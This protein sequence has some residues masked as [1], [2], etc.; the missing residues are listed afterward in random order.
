MS[1]P[2]PVRTLI[3]GLTVML[4]LGLGSATAL[5][6][7]APAD[8]PKPGSAAAKAAK[9]L[10]QY[11]ATGETRQC[12]PLIQIDRSDVVDDQNILFHMRGGKTY[13]NT[14]PYRCP[15]LGFEESFSYRTSLNQ[16][17]NVDIITVF[18][19]T[20]FHGPSCGLGDFKEVVKK[21]AP[22]E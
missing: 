6:Q 2:L 10:A 20:G 16:L 19:A 8:A 11:E 14:L 13:L 12:I 5:A 1:R 3:Q 4:A 21:E 7:D 22:T 9:K 18:D 17:C 15:R